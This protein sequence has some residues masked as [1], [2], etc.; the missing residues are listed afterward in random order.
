MM[1]DQYLVVTKL[2]GAGKFADTATNN[3][4]PDLLIT[5][6]WRKQFLWGVPKSARKDEGAL[7]ARQ[8]DESPPA[9]FCQ[10]D[11]YVRSADYLNLKANPQYRELHTRTDR[12]WYS[13]SVI[14]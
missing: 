2:G 8:K 3:V 5:S 9:H 6:Q 13:E 7:H 1:N 12:Q 11:F 14:P 4:D 10:I